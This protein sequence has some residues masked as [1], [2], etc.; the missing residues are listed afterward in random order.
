[1]RYQLEIIG[2]NIEACIT[3]QASGA[4]RIEL[5][6][7]VAAG[8]T[9]PSY[10]FIK[11]AREVLK[12][13][14]YPIIRPRAGDFHFTQAEF[15]VMKADVLI[16]KKLGCDGVVIGMLTKD[17]SIDKERCSQLVNHAYPMGVT[18]HRA[19]DRVADAAVA[20]ETIIDLGC[21]RVLTS[22]LMPNAESGI[23]NIADLV[24]QAAGR[25]SIMPG[26]GIRSANLENIASETGATE[27]HSSALAS[28]VS[29]MEFR[30]DRMQENLASVSVDDQEIKN[31]L[32]ILH[33]LSS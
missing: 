33:R 8:G 28:V 16:C 17:G 10:G 31:M 26:S 23:A 11:V 27:F 22:G 6:D 2:Y 9:T 30:N 21:E 4:H 1:M 15:D 24:R 20:L 18:F 32:S 7:N 25:I 13:P 29:S 19:F 3:A 14:L 12:I 5:C